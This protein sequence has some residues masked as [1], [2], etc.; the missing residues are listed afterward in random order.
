[1]R[2]YGEREAVQP[3]YGLSSSGLGSSARPL[4][5]AGTGTTQPKTASGTNE[6]ENHSFIW[7]NSE[8]RDS[9]GAR[10]FLSEIGPTAED[11]DIS[12]C[13]ITPPNGFCC[14]AAKVS[15]LPLLAARWFGGSV[16]CVVGRRGPA[17]LWR[18]NIHSSVDLFEAVRYVR[19]TRFA[20]AF[21]NVMLER[22]STSWSLTS[23]QYSQLA[24]YRQLVNYFINQEHVL[25]GQA[26]S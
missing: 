20:E 7:I 26:N 21:R 14:P 8:A 2:T 25:H 12:Y 18:R 13:R 6:N 9:I 4:C 10:S 22:S 19:T 24:G 11:W 5:C 16:C 3:R 1:M 15:Q 23:P 17:I